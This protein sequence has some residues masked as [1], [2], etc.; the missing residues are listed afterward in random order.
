MKTTHRFPRR[1]AARANASQRSKLL[2]AFDRSGASA[3]AFARQHAINY[4]TFCGWRQRRATAKPSPA[5]VFARLRAG[6]TAD[7]GSAN[8]AD[9]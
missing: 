8:F 4:T 6:G 7:T 5:F 2:A 3:A 9:D 1:R